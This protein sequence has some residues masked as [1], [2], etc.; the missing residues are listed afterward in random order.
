MNKIYYHSNEFFLLRDFP[1]EPTGYC[2][3]LGAIA[4]ICGNTFCRC[5]SMLKRHIKA[6]KSCIAAKTRIDNPEALCIVTPP[7]GSGDLYALLNGEQIKLENGDIFDL[8]DNVEFE[9]KNDQRNCNYCKIDCLKNLKGIPCKAP[10]VIH[11]KLKQEV[12]PFKE[13]KSMEAKAKWLAY[14]LEIG[15]IDKSQLDSLDKLWDKFKDPEGNFKKEKEES[16]D[17]LWTEVTRLHNIYAFKE[18]SDKLKSK[19]TI[20]RK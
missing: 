18:L 20:Q 8:P 9:E 14:C 11:L 12:S 6:I 5:D 16:Q 10:R 1:E 19:F 15:F 7:D 4:L 3:D 17:E 2:T 13:R